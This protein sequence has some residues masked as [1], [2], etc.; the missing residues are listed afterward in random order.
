MTQ[1]KNKLLKFNISYSAVQGFY[2]T[3][4]SVAAIY[5]SVYM[6]AKGY[7]NT[8]VGMVIAIGNISSVLCQSVLSNIADR[9]PKVTNLLLLKLLTG[10][11]FAFTGAVFLIGK[12]CF[13]LTFCYTFV[14]IVFT[15]MQPFANALGFD[16][17]RSSG[18]H[19]SFGIARAA[20]SLLAGIQ[21]YFVGVLVTKLGEDSIMWE[22]LLVVVAIFLSFVVSGM[23]M[24]SSDTDPAKADQEK[25]LSL[26]EFI[27]GHKAFIILSLG[28]VLLFFGNAVLENFIYQI[29]V[30]IGGDA[31]QMG[32]VAA[33]G[34]I[35]EVPAMVCFDKII[36][37]FSY[38]TLL[39]VASV[40][41]L[42][43]VV[44]F[45]FAGSLIVIYLAYLN[46]ILGYGLIFPAMV[47]FIDNIM[48]KREAIRGQAVFTMAM[49]I[50]QV[51]GMIIGGRILD[52]LSVH[53]LLILSTVL[54]AIAVL[55]FSLVIRKVK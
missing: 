11:L 48:D 30:S 38:R 31:S 15:T 6:L 12:N 45:L 20:G 32:A 19:V 21:C 13:T 41:F 22:G 52:L 3:F 33:V 5:V 36:K 55:I 35:M 26:R 27:S 24:K 37:H 2:W 17:E 23:L 28:V 51:L 7:S 8:A 40:F 29:V 39:V 34:A 1:E 46:Q 9:N 44:M 43:K 18:I 53:A 42:S 50:G 16:L 54:T 4:Y 25:A 14:I 47:G 49:T 10:L